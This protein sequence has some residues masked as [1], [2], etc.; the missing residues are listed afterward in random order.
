M[1]EAGGHLK[2]LPA[3][4]LNIYNVFEHIDMLSIDI[5]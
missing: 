5:W 1:V 3:P 4:T 2:Q